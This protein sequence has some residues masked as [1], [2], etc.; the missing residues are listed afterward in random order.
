MST[1]T[2]RINMV[3]GN[4]EW[5]FVDDDD[6]DYNQ[7]LARSAFADM[8]HDHERNI[9]YE[10]AI[11]KT[12][13]TLSK[14][15]KKIHVLDIGTG[16]GLLSMMA[17]RAFNQTIDSS[18]SLRITA[19]EVFQ[20]MAKIAKK[21]IE[22]NSLSHCIRVI[23]KRSTELDLEK[24]LQGDRI[25]IIVAEVF[26]TEL[27]GE[28]A[29]RTFSEAC[30]HLT[31][32]N[33]NLRIIPARATIY[34]Q[35]VQSSFLQEFHTLK[36]LSET[37]PKIKIPDDCRHL[38]GNTIFDLN[39]NEIKNYIRPL[40]KPIPVFDFDFK[41]LNDK[42]NFTNE[43]IL[44]NIQ[45]DYDGQ[46]DAFVMWWNLDM[47]EQGEI[48]LGTIPSWCYDDKEK[49]QNVQWREHWIH[50]IYYPQQPKIVKAKDQVSLYCFHDEYSLYF[51]VGTLP[52]PSKSFTPTY[53]S[54]SAVAGFNNDKRRNKYIQALEKSFS[55]P[56]INRCLYIGD[57]LLLPLL[58]LEMYPN[59]ELIILQSSNIHLA[60]TLEAIL[61]NSSKQLN[62]RIIPSLD[63]ENIDFQTI[64][65]ILSEPFFTKSILPWDNLHFYYLIQQYHHSNIKL[66]PSKARIRCIAL[67]FDNLYKIRSPV[68]QCCQF[69]LTPFDEQILQASLNVDATIEPQS[70]FEY[71]S[72]KP[73]LS[74]IIDLI[75]I[76]LEKISEKNKIETIN[77]DIPFNVDGICNGI[78]FWIDYQL[79]DNIWLTT[80]IENENDSWVNYSK[81]G[82]HLL[83]KPIEIKSGMKLSINA[84]FDFQQGQFS[85]NIIS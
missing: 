27:I 62:Y 17:A 50:A 29:L 67:E 52:F 1:F 23:D 12:I 47:D 75:E 18:C 80:G 7:E 76:D 60:H 69:D 41:S 9:Q 59:I 55:N 42:N 85:F 48:Q 15:T 10:K 65:M 11:I 70:L 81:Q 35:L 54:R 31:I 43:K 66:F 83:L 63:K 82:V 56:S 49:E 13:Q 53:L 26:D 5:I 6:F 19:C 28:G 21:C 45:C 24:D 8:L 25:N 73:T 51:D 22:K 30:K 36:N 57:G 39:A 3:T 71:S 34:V 64:D 46:I 78:A 74:S 4:N 20:P 77:L 40:S 68:K 32:D 2:S 58:I 72:K 44:E 84:A 16:T 37:N 79:E 14:S 33:E 61:K 38:A